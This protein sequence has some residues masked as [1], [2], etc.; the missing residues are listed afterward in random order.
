MTIILM[1]SK[2]MCSH[3]VLQVIVG[4]VQF[5][6]LSVYLFQICSRFPKRIH[7]SLDYS[8]RLAFRCTLFL[9]ICRSWRWMAWHFSPGATI[10]RDSPCCSG[11]WRTRVLVS[12]CCWNFIV[13]FPELVHKITLSRHVIYW[14]STI[15]CSLSPISAAY[16][17]FYTIFTEF[18]IER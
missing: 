10:S 4:R 17:L 13:N 16:F 12:H 9:W 11:I 1:H 5:I 15:F 3:L 2:V 14:S 7:L 18:L 8:S 6:G